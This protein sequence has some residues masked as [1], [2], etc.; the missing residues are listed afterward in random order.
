[1]N[2]QRGPLC[3]KCSKRICYPRGI[4]SETKIDINN[5]PDFCPMKISTEALEKARKEY[6]KEDIKEFARLAA[7]QEAECYEWI[8][9]KIKPKI[10]RVEETIQFAKKMN[11]KKLGLVF[12]VGLANESLILNKIMEN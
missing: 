10:T 12:C 3:T 5:A 6:Q 1:M 8:N 2:K 7:I 9:G 11:Y 4:A